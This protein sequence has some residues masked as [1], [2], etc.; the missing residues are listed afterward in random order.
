MKNLKLLLI[1]HAVITLAAAIV[2]VIAPALIPKT[3]DIE[4][5]HDQYLLSYFLGAAE[6][7]IAYLSFQSRKIKDRYALKIIIVSFIIFHIATG[8]LEAYG[9]TQG[10]SSKIIGN[11]VLR[12]IIVA[13][14]CYY[15]IYKNKLTGPE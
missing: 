15:G 4:I 9:L 12:I 7:G 6:L 5:A 2:L 1:I 13:L 11:I 10:L 14:F 8:L 3:V